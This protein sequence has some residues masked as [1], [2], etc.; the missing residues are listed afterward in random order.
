MNL[1][2]QISKAT[3]L[4]EAVLI[5]KILAVLEKDRYGIKR[6]TN[7]SVEFSYHNGGGWRRRSEYFKLLDSGE[8][9]IER[10][11]GKNLVKLEYLRTPLSEIIFV[12]SVFLFFL[13]VGVTTQ[14]YFCL[15]IG[16]A[17]VLQFIFRYFNL[18]SVAENMLDDITQ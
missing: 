15:F 2:R 17:F 8:F 14:T 11:E 4:D 3:N 18:K 1:S 5:E 6:L 7:N 12:A 13:I 10:S 9:L 16:L